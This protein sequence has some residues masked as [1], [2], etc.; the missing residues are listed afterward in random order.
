M[1]VH[2]RAMTAPSRIDAQPGDKRERILDAALELFAERGFHGTPVPMVAEQAKVGAGTIYRYFASKE[3]L[4]NAL[5]RREKQAV[6]ER[7]MRD[8]PMDVPPRAQFRHFFE[9]TVG[10]AK[11][12]P[13]S[14]RFLEHHH[15]APY[16]D[17]Q[18][19]AIERHALDL[20]LGYLAETARRQVTK[21]VAP[22]VLMAVV[23]GAIVHLVKEAATGRIE[24]TAEVLAQAEGACWE[25]VRL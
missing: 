11:S 20:A 3:A 10:Y 18:S 16:L 17:D 4:V 5:Y 21:P 2:S 14:F 8:F 19:R 15:H 22:E 23:W 24:L 9:T 6:L 12:H 7:V 25:A 13:N 1:I